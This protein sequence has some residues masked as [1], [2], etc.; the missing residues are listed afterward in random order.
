MFG[1]LW[2]GRCPTEGESGDVLREERRSHRQQMEGNGLD[3]AERK[4]R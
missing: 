1:E 4:A 2:G 3:K